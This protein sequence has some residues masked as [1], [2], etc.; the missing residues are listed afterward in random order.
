MISN[1]AFIKDLY[2]VLIK[3]VKWSHEFISVKDYSFDV[4]DELYIISAKH[5]IEFNEEPLVLI[6]NLLDFYCDAV[7]HQFKML[8]DSYSVSEAAN[9]IGE[10]IKYIE[11]NH[12]TSLDLNTNLKIKLRVIFKR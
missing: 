10:I 8:D 7:K 1:K 3:V 11:D 12:F 9:D 2:T 6:Y 5:H 4:D